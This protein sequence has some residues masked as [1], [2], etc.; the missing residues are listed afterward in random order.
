[1][2][3]LKSSASSKLYV[4]TP[5]RDPARLFIADWPRNGILVEDAEEEGERKERFQL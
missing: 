3:G 4:F 2:F 1:M 5:C